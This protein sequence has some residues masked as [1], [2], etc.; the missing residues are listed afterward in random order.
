MTYLDQ[1]Q[2]R[3]DA[4]HLRGKRQDAD[5]KVREWPHISYE[6]AIATYPH[7]KGSAEAI[8]E[9]NRLLDQEAIEWHE[10]ELAE[11]KEKQ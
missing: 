5:A 10:Q 4:S 3:D 6:D 7:L 8:A 11:L 2:E 1:F 9:L